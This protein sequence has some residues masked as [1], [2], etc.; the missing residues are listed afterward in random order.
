MEARRGG[1]ED[2]RSLEPS[3]PGYEL[4]V[5]IIIYTSQEGDVYKLEASG[6]TTTWL[7]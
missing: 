4:L 2:K 1:P 6:W 3:V 5:E 7:T